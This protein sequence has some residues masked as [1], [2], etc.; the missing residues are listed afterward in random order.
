MFCS[1]SQLSVGSACGCFDRAGCVWGL[2][3]VSEILPFIFLIPWAPFS[4][5]SH[6]LHQ[7]PYSFTYHVFRTALFWWSW[8]SLKK[9]KEVQQD[10]S[11]Q[12]QTRLSHY[13]LC[14]CRDALLHNL[15]LIRPL[16]LHT[17]L[18]TILYNREPHPLFEM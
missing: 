6:L 4:T 7:L 14:K 10:N 16:L 3:F 13:L 5:E 9:K 15:T 12:S 1:E 11:A 18:S 8:R 2:R 17:C